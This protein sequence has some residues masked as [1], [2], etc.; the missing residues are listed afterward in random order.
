MFPTI[1]ALG[2]FGL[3]AR[4]KKAS[5]FLVMAIMGGAILPKLMGAV[6]DRATICRAA[7]S[8]RPPVSP[9]W[10]HSMASPTWSRYSTER[11]SLPRGE[12]PRLEQGVGWA[13]PLIHAGQ[14]PLSGVCKPGASSGPGPSYRERY[15]ETAFTGSAYASQHWELY[16]HSRA[17]HTINWLSPPPATRRIQPAAPPRRFPDGRSLDVRSMRRDN[18]ATTAG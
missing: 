16:I 5:A 18:C 17:A 12:E 1:F 15:S 14:H 11:G 13:D 2:I 6:A 8:C 10:W 9:S 4:A 7:S 3:G